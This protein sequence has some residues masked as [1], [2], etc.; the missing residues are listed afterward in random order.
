MASSSWCSSRRLS[1]GGA[2]PRSCCPS[3]KEAGASAGIT[4][5]HHH[6]MPDSQHIATRTISS[7]QQAETNARRMGAKARIK[8]CLKDR[9]SGN[10]RGERLHTRTYSPPHCL[11]HTQFGRATALTCSKAAADRAEELRLVYVYGL[12]PLEVGRLPGLHFKLG[13]AIAP[14]PS[15]RS[16]CRT[17]VQGRGSAAA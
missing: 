9:R 4:P 13:P 10:C 15:E 3:S 1:G 6:T 2:E 17:G 8:V 12:A 5:N 16:V 14:K 7:A 11:C